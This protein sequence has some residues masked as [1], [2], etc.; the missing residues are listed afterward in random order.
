M[1]QL[2][3]LEEMGEGEGVVVYMLGGG[4]GGGEDERDG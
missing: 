1:S 2:C 3:A 4:D